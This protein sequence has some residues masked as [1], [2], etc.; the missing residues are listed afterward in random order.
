MQR[1]QKRKLD[2][3]ANA[4]FPNALHFYTFCTDRFFAIFS[5][6]GE[7]YCRGI[8]HLTSAVDG[9]DWIASRRAHFNPEKNYRDSNNGPCSPE[10]SRYTYYVPPAV[11]ATGSKRKLKNRL[12]EALRNKT[13]VTMFLFNTAAFF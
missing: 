12:V 2:S 1:C 5:V 9:G 8:L 10:P 13:T 7:R 4:P 11:I 3:E 6:A